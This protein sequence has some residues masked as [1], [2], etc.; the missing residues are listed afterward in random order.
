MKTIDP[1]SVTNIA[2]TSVRVAM[3]RSTVELLRTRPELSFVLV[4]LVATFIDGLTKAP[5][6]KTH[7]AYV[8]YLKSNFPELCAALGAEAFYAHI[9]CAAIHEFAPRPPLALA[10]DAELQGRYTDTRELEGQHWTLLNADRLVDEF[11]RHLDRIS[12]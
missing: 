9:R 11:L 7:D 4:S 6:R 2:D 3:M 1:A 10:P 12:A 8:E 5:P